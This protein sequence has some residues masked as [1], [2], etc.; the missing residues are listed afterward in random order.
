MEEGKVYISHY[1]K[2]TKIDKRLFGSFVEH[3]GS[4]VYTGIYEPTHPTAILG[5]FRGDVLE[6]VKELNLGVVRYPGGNFTSGYN[7]K[8]T[9]GPVEKRPKKLE[10]AWQGIEPNEFGLNEFITWKN[11]LEA[12]MIMTI[13]LGTKGIEDAIS[14][15]EYCNFPSGTYWSDLRI[16]HGF[17]Q[18][19]N[20]K[21]WCLGNE[22]DGEWQIGTKTPEDYGKLAKQASKV[23]K[24]VDDS[25]ETILVGSSHPRLDTYPEWD[26]KV[27]M[28][29]YEDVDYLAMHN[30][31]DRSQDETLNV[32]DTREPD[33]TATYLARSLGFDKQIK[34]MIAVCD[35]VKAVKRSD[36]T[37]NIAFDEWNVHK[38]SEE[39]Y[40][41][42]QTGSSID[43]C[44]FTM[45]DSLLFGA[46]GL[47]ILR[48][49]ERIKISCQSLLVNTIPLILT[50]ENGDAWVNPTYFIM[51]D[52]ATYGKGT[53][54]EHVSNIPIYQTELYKNVPGLD[55][56]VVDDG[57]YINTFIIN[58]LDTPTMFKIEMN[59]DY[60]L[61]LR[62]SIHHILESENLT[63][64]NRKNDSNAVTPIIQSVDLS[65]HQVE[66]SKY[67]WNILRIPYRVI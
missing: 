62:K 50:E 6:L 44:H 27:L 46:M 53:L 61:I 19:H 12:E 21:L 52:L 20:I 54:I 49:S 11:Q 66:I 41:K 26:R 22:L 2:K 28:E 34:E 13:N 47:S 33:D 55:T 25:I 4:V 48:N 37:M 59:L 9:I 7:W 38:H 57:E 1:M 15:V 64:I 58:K 31:I 43:R 60:D 3:M 29:A 51:K 8:D 36:K 63:D 10:L 42:W 65:N 16:E 5:G 67:S 40:N 24:L 45:E 17:E 23:M 39:E 18:P 35:Y 30:Y 56:V 32:V 14:I